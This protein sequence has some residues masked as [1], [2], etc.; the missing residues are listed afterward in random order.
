MFKTETVCLH[1]C[2][3]FE[4]LNT[5]TEPVS[6]FFTSPPY[7]I[8]SQSPKRCL[9]LRKFGVFD[10]KSWGGIED[11]PDQLPE[12][13]YQKQQHDLLVKFHDLVEANGTVVYNHKDRRRD[14]SRILPQGH[15]VPLPGGHA[16]DEACP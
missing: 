11:Y 13:V 15:H 5:L 2:D 14:Y 8:G 4:F 3:C 1:N 6:L 9:G 16:R 7:N 10:P 12:D